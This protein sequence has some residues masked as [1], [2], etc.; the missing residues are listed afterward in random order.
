MPQGITLQ[1][2][3]YYRLKVATTDLYGWKEF[4]KNFHTYSEISMEINGI[5]P[6]Y[7]IYGEDVTLRNTTITDNISVVAHDFVY[8]LPN[9]YLE[10]GIYSIEKSL[11]CD[12]FAYNLPKN[13]PIVQGE[14]KRGEI[15]Y[16]KSEVIDLKEDIKNVDDSFIVYPN[17]TTGRITIN[18]GEKFNN[19]EISLFNIFG[20][21]PVPTIS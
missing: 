8:I 1:A 12:F 21:T 5:D 14:N 16:K 19:G 2:D 11:N 20:S 15:D 3:K 13:N 6:F 17:P 9:S 4:V 7:D 10:S 18:H